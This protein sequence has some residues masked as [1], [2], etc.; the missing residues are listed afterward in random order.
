MRPNDRWWCNS[1]RKWKKCH[2]GRDEQSQLPVGQH[3]AKMREAMQ[4]KYCSH[5]ETGPGCSNTIVNSHTIQKRG[6]LTAISERGHVLSVQA[7]FEQIH[8][9]SGNILPI[10]VGV[11]T[12][13]TFT[14]FCDTHDDE[15]F[16]I[17]EKGPVNLNAEG[18]FVLSYRALAYEPYKKNTAVSAAE[19]HLQ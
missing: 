17:A 5:P 8:R 11:G 18:S 2:R 6:G 14:G 13:S 7:A 9:N 16:A 12:A 19:I 15:M 1:G 4:L 3:V 10:P